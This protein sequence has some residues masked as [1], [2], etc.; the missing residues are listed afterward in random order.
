MSSLADKLKIEELSSGSSIVDSQ[1]SFIETIVDKFKKKHRIAF[2]DHIYKITK[3]GHTI[4]QGFTFV[5][6]NSLKLERVIKAN[7]NFA[8]DDRNE[9][10]GAVASLVTKGTGYRELGEGMDKSL[11]LAIDRGECSVHLDN[12]SF[13]GV[14]LNGM[15]FYNPDK[16]QHVAYDL[17]W[18]D[19]IVRRLYGVWKP[20]GWTFDRVRPNFFN[21]KTRYSSW[22]A[23]IDI[24]DSENLSVSFDYERHIKV[25]DMFND[26][27]V[28]KKTDERLMLNFGGRF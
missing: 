23:G 5:P 6:V 28:I 20:F 9:V 2:L 4:G 14:G 19:Q 11:H 3:A 1:R 22:G 15:P 8:A 25:N 12:T 17:I 21:S 7:S 13:R 24:F 26:L 18:D 27:D 10:V 16:F